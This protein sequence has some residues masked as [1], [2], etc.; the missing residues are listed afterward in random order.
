MDEKIKTTYALRFKT[1]SEIDTRSKARRCYKSTLLESDLH[2]FWA[3][4][5]NAFI[6][7]R[8]RLTDDELQF[9]IQVLHGR[10]INGADLLLWG[11]SALIQATEMA[12][13]TL[14]KKE[15]VGVS[16]GTLLSKL[17][18]LSSLQRMALCDWGC[19]QWLNKN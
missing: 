13:R 16:H 6:E 19:R 9:I 12:F 4:L 8:E 7:A 3:M 17:S 15:T 2:A 14:N 1:I 11:D 18:K 5:R 10:E